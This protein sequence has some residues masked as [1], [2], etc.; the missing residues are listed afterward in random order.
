MTES[1]SDRTR[2]RF[3]W[4]VSQ[5]N[6]KAVAKLRESV[7]F[8]LSEEETEHFLRARYGD[9]YPHYKALYDTGRY[10]LSGGGSVYHL[11]FMDCSSPYAVHH[12]FKIHAP[13]HLPILFNAPHNQH[14]IRHHPN[15]AEGL[16]GR[17][18]EAINQAQ[19]F[20]AAIDDVSTCCKTYKRARY[21]LS[22]W[23]SANAF[24]PDYVRKTMAKRRFVRP[25]PKSVQ[26]FKPETLQTL[27][28]M[29]LIEPYPEN[30]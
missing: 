17:I 9:D 5:W 16:P 21:I 27:A 10:P 6:T 7:D 3:T 14:D 24:M 18:V 25:V 28:L 23:A 8:T 29:S 15:W 11:Y 30:T 22:Q 12:W 13:R 4:N 26:A 1:L 19:A 20:Q 2:D